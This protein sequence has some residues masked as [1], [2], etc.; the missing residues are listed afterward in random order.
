MTAVAIT[1]IGVVSA[2]GHGV[3]PFWRGL[4]AGE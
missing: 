2:F 4:V 1:G 3:E